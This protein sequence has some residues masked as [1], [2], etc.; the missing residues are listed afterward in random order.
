VVNGDQPV[1]QL[2]DEVVRFLSSRIQ[3]LT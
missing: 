3:L 1:K 2:A